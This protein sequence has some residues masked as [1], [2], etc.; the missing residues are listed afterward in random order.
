MTNHALSWP[1]HSS[2]T[3]IVCNLRELCKDFVLV[4]YIT[5]PTMHVYM[6][7]WWWPTMCYLGLDIHRLLVLYVTELCKDFVFVKY[8]Q[9]CISQSLIFN[10]HCNSIE[11]N[12]P[13]ATP[14]RRCPFM[15]I[16]IMYII[17]PNSNLPIH[18]ICI[19]CSPDWIS[20]M[21]FYIMI[22]PN[23]NLAILHS[24]I[25][26]QEYSKHRLVYLTYISDSTQ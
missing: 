20:L 8:D 14:L 3:S 4:K 19:W 25:I 1:W 13:Y 2:T 15:Y 23:V 18:N 26:S 5:W 22:M 11:L 7:Q 10:D 21:C 17:M 9:P 24:I 12:L 6:S 16:H